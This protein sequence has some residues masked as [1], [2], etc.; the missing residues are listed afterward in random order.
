[1]FSLGLNMRNKPT[2]N[3]S[4]NKEENFS[5]AVGMKLKEEGVKF[6][7]PIDGSKHMFTPENVVDIQCN[8]GS[9]IMMVL[10]VCS[11]S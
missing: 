6:A 3:L 8:F 5:H 4:L 10:D 7:S 11:P 9:D 1:M 2:P